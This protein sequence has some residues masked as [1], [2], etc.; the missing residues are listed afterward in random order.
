MKPLLSILVLWA[1]LTGCAQPPATGSG[2]CFVVQF[3]EPTNTTGIVAYDLVASSDAT[4]WQWVAFCPVGTNQIAFSPNQLPAAS[5][6]LAVRSEAQFNGQTL[7]S[8]NSDAVQFN[9]VNWSRPPKPG[10]PKIIKK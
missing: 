3:T 2:Q 6:F 9:L 5:C 4:N 10:L 7:I 1:C 8:D